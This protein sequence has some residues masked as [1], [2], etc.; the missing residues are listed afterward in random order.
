MCIRD[1]GY[2]GAGGIGS[3]P[4]AVGPATPIGTRPAPSSSLSRR[5]STTPALRTGRPPAPLSAPAPGCG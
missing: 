5:S 2:R 1:S 3:T 4:R